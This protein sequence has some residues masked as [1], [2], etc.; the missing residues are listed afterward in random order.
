MAETTYRP[1]GEDLHRKL[2][3]AEK[4]VGDI[5]SR[6]G[7]DL[8]ELHRARMALSDAEDM[9]RYY[10]DGKAHGRGCD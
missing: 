6:P 1:G 7:R 5:M 4:R 10:S 8:G 9:M 2:V 3:E